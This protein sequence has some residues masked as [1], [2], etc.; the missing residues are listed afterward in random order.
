MLPFPDNGKKG[1]IEYMW[2]I[3]NCAKVSLI[4]VNPSTGK[5]TEA[6]MLENVPGLVT[7]SGQEKI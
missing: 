4:K 1:A 6:S 3:F 2:H 7:A 5:M